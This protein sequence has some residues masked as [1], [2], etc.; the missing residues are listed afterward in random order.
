MLYIADEVFFTG[1]AVE[2]SPIRSIDRVPIGAGT[3]GPV[4]KKLQ[5]AFFPARRRS[6][7]G[8]VWLVD[9]RERGGIGGMMA[10]SYLGWLREHI[11]HQKI[12]S[13][14]AVAVIRDERGRVLL[15]KRRDL[16]CGVCP[17]VLQE[18]GERV[19]ETVRHETSEEVGLEV[20][21]EA[22]HWHLHVAALG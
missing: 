6:R 16:A 8:S 7:T 15:Q 11:G 13:T 22:H 3:R 1:T 18:L 21:P 20:E 10:M 5:D 14:G 2:I 17:V 4:T 12:I 9:V 19:D